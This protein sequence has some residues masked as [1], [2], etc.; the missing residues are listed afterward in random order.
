[1]YN[2]PSVFGNKNSVFSPQQ[3]HNADRYIFH[4]GDPKIKNFLHAAGNNDWFIK[5]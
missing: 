2:M 5:E 3:L 1:M 4:G